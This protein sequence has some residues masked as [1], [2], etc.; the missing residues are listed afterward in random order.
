MKLNLDA[1]LKRSKQ[2]KLLLALLGTADESFGINDLRL[3]QEY[4]DPEDAPPGYPGRSHVDIIADYL[5]QVRKAV[6]QRLVRQYGASLLASLKKELVITVPAVWSD[7]A[8]DLTLQAVK[9]ADFKA[10]IISLVPEPEAGAVYTLKCMTEGVHKEEVKVGDMFVV[11]DAGGGTVD[12][13]SYRIAE[14][15][16]RFKLEEAVVGSGDK[17]GE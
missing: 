11:C 15:A 12:L 4:E 10:D 13:I 2:L 17:C 16:P 8:K 7:R 6:W 14:G 9:R 3:D 5:T 1:T